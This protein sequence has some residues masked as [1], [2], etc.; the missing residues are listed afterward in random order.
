MYVSCQKLPRNCRGNIEAGDQWTST[1]ENCETL[2]GKQARA[3][4]VKQLKRLLRRTDRAA[5]EDGQTGPACYGRTVSG[6]R[7]GGVW[8]WLWSLT[9]YVLPELWVGWVGFPICMHISGENMNI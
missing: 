4:T 2:P 1:R 7:F 3:M 8:V 6:V 5:A 9:Y